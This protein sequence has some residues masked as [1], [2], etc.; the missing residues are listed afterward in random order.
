[1]Y[2]CKT[3]KIEIVRE[4]IKYTKNINAYDSD[5]YTVSFVIIINEINHHI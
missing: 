2:A 5:G 4:L 3:N 1:M